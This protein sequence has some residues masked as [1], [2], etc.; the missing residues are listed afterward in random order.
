MGKEEMI[1]NNN[2]LRKPK[3]ANPRGSKT[4]SYSVKQ[5]LCWQRITEDF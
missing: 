3:H 1:S 4:E 5:N 2:N